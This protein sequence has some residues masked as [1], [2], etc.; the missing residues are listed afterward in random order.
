MR[1]TCGEPLSHFHRLE[2]IAEQD[3]SIGEGYETRYRLIEKRIT[4]SRYAACRRCNCGSGD[5][6]NRFK[7]KYADVRITDTGE[8]IY[9]AIPT[10]GCSAKCARIM[11]ALRR[12]ITGTRSSA[13][14]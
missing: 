14:R 2:F 13:L 5:T 12:L 3:S 7:L 9:Q 10:L 6:I 1:S 4:E 8:T 11:T